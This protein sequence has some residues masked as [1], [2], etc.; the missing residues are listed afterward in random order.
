MA[1]LVFNWCVWSLSQIFCEDQLE[2]SRIR[3]KSCIKRKGNVIHRNDDFQIWKDLK[4][5]AKPDFHVE[6]YKGLLISNCYTE[7]VIIR[8]DE[9]IG[10][11]VI[12]VIL[13]NCCKKYCKIIRLDS[14]FLQISGIIRYSSFTQGKE[15]WEGIEVK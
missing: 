8:K 13:A 3:C 12:A 1:A 7:S 5:T 14:S 15:K 6:N 2:S 9:I 4:T 10:E 11:C